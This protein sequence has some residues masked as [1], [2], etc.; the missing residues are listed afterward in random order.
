MACSLAAG[1]GAHTV[2]PSSKLLVARVYCYWVLKAERLRFLQCMKIGI[3]CD[4]CARKIDTLTAPHN[5]LYAALRLRSTDAALICQRTRASD[6]LSARLLCGT[7]A[8]RQATHR[9]VIN[10]PSSSSDQQR[11]TVVERSHRR[12]S[13]VAQKAAGEVRVVAARPR[14]ASCSR[15]KLSATS[16][17]SPYL[18]LPYLTLPSEGANLTANGCTHHARGGPLLFRQFLGKFLVCFARASTWLSSNADL[19]E[20]LDGQDRDPRG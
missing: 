8:G 4:V 17:L 6:R 20:D 16:G 9:M 7:L 2:R 3:L 19:R 5:P 12:Q 10:A 14:L 13:S 15:Q 18:T 1:H 11:V